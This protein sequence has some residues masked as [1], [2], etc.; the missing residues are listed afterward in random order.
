[1]H[2]EVCSSVRCPL[3]SLCTCACSCVMRVTL[4]SAVA[5]GQASFT[6]ASAASVIISFSSR[7]LRCTFRATAPESF[8]R[9]NRAC[10]RKYPP[11]NASQ[12]RT[13]DYYASLEEKGKIKEQYVELQRKWLKSERC[14]R[15]SHFLALLGCEK[16]SF[17]SLAF[18]Y[19]ISRI[20]KGVSPPLFLSCES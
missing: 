13:K 19:H 2:S 11:D 12:S 8:W 15:M 4:S 7:T 16:L 6:S 5:V 9:G 10:R 20:T 18:L 1:M 3:C 14:N 17:L